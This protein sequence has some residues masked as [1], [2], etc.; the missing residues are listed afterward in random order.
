MGWERILGL[1]IDFVKVYMMANFI[2]ISYFVSF[3][4]FLFFVEFISDEY[5]NCKMC[6]VKIKNH[7]DI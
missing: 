4:K 6:V 7:L 2:G 3:V 1:I 5:L